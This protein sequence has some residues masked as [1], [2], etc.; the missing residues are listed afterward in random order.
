[1]ENKDEIKE[2]KI[3]TFRMVLKIMKMFFFK[4]I[5]RKWYLPGV[6]EITVD[7]LNDKINSNQSPIIIDLRDRREFYGAEGSLSN[8][9]HILNAK[10]IPILDLS[11]NLKTLSSFKEK[12]IVTICP[13][14][15]MSLIA[16]ESMVKAGFDDV[17]SLKGGM[18]LWVK[19]GYTTTT[20]EDINYPLEDSKTRSLT[21]RA[22]LN[23][24]K[25]SSVEESKSEVHKTLDVRNFSCPIPV[26]KS[27]KA[28]EKLKIGQVLE[29]LT[30]DLGS[31]TDIPAW[32]HVTGQE[33][34]SAEDSGSEEYRFIVRRLK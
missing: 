30:T 2:T 1:M 22:K 16:A 5:R 13:G 32:A 4:F 25:Q 3:S 26:L 20:V 28:L 17:K 12:E 29:I 31:K 6:S 23:E 27:K 24:V 33:L 7:E 34:I 18:D 15:G 9:G 14:G 10:S 8:Y 11:V 19:K 21:S